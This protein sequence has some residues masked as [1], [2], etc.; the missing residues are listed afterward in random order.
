V[1]IK[2]IQTTGKIRRKSYIKTVYLSLGLPKL[3]FV[4]DQ[5]KTVFGSTIFFKEQIRKG[6]LLS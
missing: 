2:I 1:H 4:R 6:L 3:Q 5:D